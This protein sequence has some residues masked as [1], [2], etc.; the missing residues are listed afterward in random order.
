ML[1]V[2]GSRA[3]AKACFDPFDYALKLRTGEVI[4]FSEARIIDPE[5]IHIEVKPMDDQP[6]QNRLPYP[7]IRGMDIRIS[8]IVWVM[9]A[10][11]GS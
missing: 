4:A 3:L 1:K 10:P 9:D 5:W 11:M 2:I 7:A 8:D 6:Y